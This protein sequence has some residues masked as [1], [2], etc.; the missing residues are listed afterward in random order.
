MP[1]AANGEGVEVLNALFKDA[2]RKHGSDIRA[3]LA[4]VRSTVQELDD[5][6]REA[7][8]KALDLA[9]TTDERRH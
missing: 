2:T 6:R 1:D 5:P 7:A 9:I 4:E 3:V 8:L